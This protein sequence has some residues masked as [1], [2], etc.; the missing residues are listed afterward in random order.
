MEELDGCFNENADLVKRK[1][2]TWSDTNIRDEFNDNAEFKRLECR[3]CT[4]IAFEVLQIRSYETSAR[5][6]NCGMYYL[7]HCG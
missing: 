2:A 1:N 4:G 3:S 5:C 6:C 7:V